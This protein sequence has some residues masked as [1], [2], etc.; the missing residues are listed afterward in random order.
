ME[1]LTESACGTLDYGPPTCLYPD[2]WN[3]WVLLHT[4]KG[5]LQM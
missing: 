5:T 2:A 3:L 4:A 1:E